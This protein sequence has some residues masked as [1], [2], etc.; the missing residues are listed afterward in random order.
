MNRS[1]KLKLKL[2][3]GGGTIFF[4]E[5]MAESQEKRDQPK[6]SYIKDGFLW[7][8][9]YGSCVLGEHGLHVMANL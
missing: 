4:G 2:V 6:I 7:E 9:F 5:A 8:G 3:V 1:S